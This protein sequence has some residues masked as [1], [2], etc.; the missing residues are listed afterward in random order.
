MQLAQATSLRI[1]DERI[2]WSLTHDYQKSIILKR[3]SGLA[4]ISEPQNDL[5]GQ[6]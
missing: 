6:L 5:L 2:P 3:K 1:E 4:G